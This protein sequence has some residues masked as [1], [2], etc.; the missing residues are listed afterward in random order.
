MVITKVKSSDKIFS[1]IGKKSQV[2]YEDIVN[3]YEESSFE[4]EKVGMKAGEFKKYLTNELSN[5]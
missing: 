2:T 1:E 4:Y 5:G 3:H